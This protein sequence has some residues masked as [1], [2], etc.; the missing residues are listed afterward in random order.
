MKKLSVALMA[1]FLCGTSCTLFAQTSTKELMKERKEL[2]KASKEQLNQRSSKAARKEAKAL[3]KQGWM[4]APG[5]LPLEKQLERSYTMEY[6]INEDLTP[7]YIMGAA[8]S[9]GEHY[10]AARKQALQLAV[11]DLASKIVNEVTILVE[12]SVANKQLSNEQAESIT[13]TLS[14]SKGLVS[15]RIGR[16]MVVTEA[17]RV[18]ENANKEVMIRIAYSSQQALD[19][20]KE[21]ARQEMA[22]SGNSVVW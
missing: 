13:Q 8:M 3:A 17:Y 10:D 15:Q 12:N 7:K 14:S 1:L 2:Q 6:D 22:K 21:V 16:T 19:T 18:K 5:A 9:I 20:A 11:E 4:V